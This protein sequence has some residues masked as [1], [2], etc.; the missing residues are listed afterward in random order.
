MGKTFLSWSNHVD[1][2]LCREKMRL[3]K[4]AWLTFAGSYLKAVIRK[5]IL[6]FWKFQSW[7]FECSTRFNNVR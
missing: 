5:Q 7:I 4:Y 6:L 3:Y 2:K 1:N